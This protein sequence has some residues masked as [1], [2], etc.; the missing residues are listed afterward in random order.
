[1]PHREKKRER[2]REK[3][4]RKEKNAYYNTLRGYRNYSTVKEKWKR[5]N[6]QGRDRDDEVCH[7]SRAVQLRNWK[8]GRV[9]TH[10]GS[11]A[12]VFLSVPGRSAE[13]NGSSGWQDGVVRRGV[14]PR[15]SPTMEGSW[16]EVI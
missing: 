12:R 14:T 15:G 9:E 1:M 13:S 16:N 10:Q 2:E 4:K 11:I 3:E 5:K 8:G 7:R 6:M